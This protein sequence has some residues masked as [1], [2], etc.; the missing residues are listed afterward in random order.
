MNPKIFL[1]IGVGL[2]GW[3]LLKTKGTP[4]NLPANAGDLPIDIP[5][6]KVTPP[7]KTL[8]KKGKK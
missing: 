5:K 7:T 8:N 2:F 3:A 4:D 6:T 1:A